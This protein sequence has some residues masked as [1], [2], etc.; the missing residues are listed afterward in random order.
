LPVLH[1]SASRQLVH[2]FWSPGP[3]VSVCLSVC[4]SEKDEQTDARRWSA[5]QFWFPRILAWPVSGARAS[6]GGS[7]SACPPEC[8]CHCVSLLLHQVYKAML[9]G[10]IPVAVKVLTDSSAARV[11]EFRKEVAILSRLHNSHIVQFQVR[12]GGAAAVLRARKGDRVRSRKPRFF[13]PACLSVCLPIHLPVRPSACV[14]VCLS[15]HP[16]I[17][18]PACPHPVPM[19]R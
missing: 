8:A 5:R 11:E 2:I 10:V 19:D 9:R 18:P 12:A 15:V 6:V 16:F 4:L 7:A 14:P 17:C 3:L 13:V 1:G